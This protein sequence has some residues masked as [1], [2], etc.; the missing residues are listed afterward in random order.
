MSLDPVLI[1]LNYE[2]D[3]HEENLDQQREEHGLELCEREE[4]D[5]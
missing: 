3:C 4:T 5:V 2:N 1:F